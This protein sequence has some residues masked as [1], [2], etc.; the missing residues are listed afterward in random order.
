MKHTLASQ[1]A[2]VG[3]LNF[4]S[5]IDGRAS[6]L[7]RD[8]NICTIVLKS[9]AVCTSTSDRYVP[10]IAYQGKRYRQSSKRGNIIR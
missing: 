4:L 7:I 10:S 8:F 6:Y 5:K 9:D 1:I 2:S 3:V